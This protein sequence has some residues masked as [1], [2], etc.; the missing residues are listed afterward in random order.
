MARALQSADDS[1]RVVCDHNYTSIVGG[2]CTLPVDV[3][4]RVQAQ[5]QK[6]KEQLNI[7]Q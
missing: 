6:N 5:Q 4:R 7:T 2:V 3:T 1:T